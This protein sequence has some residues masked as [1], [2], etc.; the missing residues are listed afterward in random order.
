[1]YRHVEL[2]AVPMIHIVDHGITNPAYT[3]GSITPSGPNTADRLTAES[4]S[5]NYFLGKNIITLLMVIINVHIN[6][7]RVDYNLVY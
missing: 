1:M 4:V 6:L 2:V 3:V 5:S 7:T